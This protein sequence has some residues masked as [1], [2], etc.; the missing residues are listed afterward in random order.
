VKAAGGGGVN[1]PAGLTTTTLLRRIVMAEGNSTPERAGPYYRMSDDHQEHSIERQQSQVRPYAAARGYQVVREYQDEGIPGD[2]VARRPQ[3]RRLLADAV[4]GHFDVIL[5]D[6]VD[7]FGRFDPIKYGAFVDPIREAG[8]RLETE[9]QGAIDWGDTLSVLNDAMRM[10]FKRERSRH[11]A[12]RILTHLLDMAE[13]GEWNGKPP[14]RLPQGPGDETAGDR[15]QGGRD[16][17]LAVRH[18]RRPG[19]EPGLAG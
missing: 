12:R 13:R 8:V 1:D 18:L 15:P 16:R 19:R 9:A 5:C 2:E 6:D 7:R 11:T 14:L 17:P 10:A 4:A 3:F